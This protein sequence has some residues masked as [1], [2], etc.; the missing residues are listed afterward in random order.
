MSNKLLSFDL[1]D[2]RLPRLLS[3]QGRAEPLGGG[4]KPKYPPVAMDLGISQ[5]ALARL[6]SD[7][8]KKW[9]LTSYD[10]VEVPDDLLDTEFFRIR[11]RSADQYQALVA[12][13]LRREGLKTDKISLVLPDHLARVALLPFE[14]LPRGRRDMLEMIRWRMKKAVP[15][16]VEEATVDYQV[17]PNRGPGATVLAVL[18]PSAILEEHESVFTHQGI[19]PGLVDLSSFSLAHLYRG[20]IEKDLPDGGDFMILNA[21]HHFFT[22]MIYRKGVPIF[23]RCKTYAFGG[24]EDE[25]SGVR[26]VHREA[27]AS[28]LYYQERLSGMELARV[29]M[30]VVGHEPERVAAV[31]QGAPVATPP[32]VIDV[33]RVVEVSGRVAAAGADRSFETLQRLAPAVGAALGREA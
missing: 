28:L 4:L 13:A 17:L 22:V 23:Y 32:E 5:L 26:L 6:G 3:S 15:F 30:R 27:Q 9:S 14:E 16:K 33:G 19:H 12:K 7:K 29:Y 10:L 25:D 2:L 1:K 21:T 18:M 24:E 31:F 20:V 8:E 11:I